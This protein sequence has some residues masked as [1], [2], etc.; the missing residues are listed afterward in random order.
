MFVRASIKNRG[1]D[2]R[3]S[4]AQLNSNSYLN[5][6]HLPVAQDVRVAVLLVGELRSF[7]LTS[8]SIQAHV[9]SSIGTE[10]VDVFAA[11]RPLPSA[12]AGT[13][14]GQVRSALSNVVSCHEVPTITG[15]CLAP[16]FHTS[17]THIIFFLK[18][19]KCRA[20]Q[21]AVDCSCAPDGSNGRTCQLPSLGMGRV[22]VR[23]GGN[24]WCTCGALSVSSPRI[25]FWYNA[26]GRAVSINAVQPCDQAESRRVGTGGH[27]ICRPIFRT[28]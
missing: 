18:P 11:I 10:F 24:I 23:R 3:G 5:N 7:S 22:V 8:S 21:L 12:P 13:A 1:F 16:P 25:C 28:V 19:S 2:K 4:A 15:A 17:F 9:I 26:A 27:A 14:C 6:D 20:R